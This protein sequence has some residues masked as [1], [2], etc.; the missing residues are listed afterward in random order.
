M[1]ERRRVARVS[2]LIQRTL[3]DIIQRELKDPRVSFCTVSQVEVSSDLRYADIKVSIVGDQKQKQ[4]AIT[5]LKRATGFLRREVAQ[6]IG[7]RHA[8][9]LRFEVDE[10]VERLMQIDRLLKQVHAEE[11]QIPIPSDADDNGFETI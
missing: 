4:D 10:A 8:P 9:E 11:K 5:G 3:S 2:T 6:R 1:S 7:L